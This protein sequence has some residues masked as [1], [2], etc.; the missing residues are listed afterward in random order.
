[1]RVRKARQEDLPELIDFYHC[2]WERTYSGI[3]PEQWNRD[4]LASLRRHFT[5]YLRS[6]NAC[7]CLAFVSL[8]ANSDRDPPLHCGQNS[9]KF[10]PDEL[11]GA[12]PLRWK[13]HGLMYIGNLLVKEGERGKGVGTQLFQAAEALAREKGSHKL[14]LYTSPK[15]PRTIAFYQ[16]LGFEQE[17]FLKR[18][19]YKE[20]ML[21]L[22]KQLGD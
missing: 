20:D 9:A 1:M 10:C 13:H 5:F 18:H 22:T 15:L 7:I 21:L 3:L 6:P 11:V 12:L 14:V 2:E 17:G 19:F 8:S 4:M 16:K